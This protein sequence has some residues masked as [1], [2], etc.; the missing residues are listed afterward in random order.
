MLRFWMVSPCSSGGSFLDHVG[1]WPVGK[2]YGYFMYSEWLCCEARRQG[3]RIRIVGVECEHFGGKS[4]GF[5]APTENYALAHSYFY[6]HNRD[7]MPYL[8]RDEPN[9]PDHAA[10]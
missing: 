6:E 10:K 4:S 3:F 2:P 7:V 5:I 9:L 8:V 1:G